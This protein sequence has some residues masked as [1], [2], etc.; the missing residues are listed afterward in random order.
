MSALLLS[1]SASS[2]EPRVEPA[3]EPAAPSAVAPVEATAADCPAPRPGTLTLATEP[4]TVVA[5]DGVVV[6]TTPL[7]RY[8]LSAGPHQLALSNGARGVAVVEDV[9]IAEGRAHKLKLL[10]ATASGEA[11]LD[12]AVSGDGGDAEVECIDDDAAAFVTVDTR[13]WSKVFIDGKLAGVTPVFA[14]KVA[15][16]AHAV[17][18][19]SGNG[20]AQVVR[21][22][23]FTAAAGETVKVVLTMSDPSDDPADDGLDVR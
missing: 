22:A 11:V 3:V 10:L 4:W 12:D 1:T 16:G 14:H 13:P 9:V 8:E 17:V 19:Q 2:A 15:A 23:R 7:Y 20:V 21:A 5:V 18:L 6:G